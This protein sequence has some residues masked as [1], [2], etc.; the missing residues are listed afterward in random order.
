M[1]ILSLSCQERAILERFTIE[2]SDAK[3]LR[4]AQTLL[5]V[6]RG[7][8]I[9]EVA[10]RQ[11][12]SEQ[13]IYNWLKRYKARSQLILEQRLSDAPRSGRPSKALGVIEPLILEVIEEDPR[14]LGYNASNWTAS[15]LQQ[16]LQRQ[17]KIEVS[18]RSVRAAI[19]RIDFRWKRPRYALSLRPKTWRQS[20]GGLNA[21]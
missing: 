11:M 1:T 12:V 10:A 3:Q 6:A 21:A 16:Y 14:G 9:S 18:S 17:H 7:E 15:L 2:T 8:S 5:W 4:R 13:T 19:A 20:K